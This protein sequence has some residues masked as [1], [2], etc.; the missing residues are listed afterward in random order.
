MPDIYFGN[1]VGY[2]ESLK[3]IDIGQMNLEDR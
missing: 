2:D 3:I 1:K